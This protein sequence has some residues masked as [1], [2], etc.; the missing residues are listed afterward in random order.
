[1]QGLQYLKITAA[2]PGFN[3]Q[4]GQGCFFLPPGQDKLWVPLH[5]LSSGYLALFH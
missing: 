2:K 4:E 3:T 5:L 1:M